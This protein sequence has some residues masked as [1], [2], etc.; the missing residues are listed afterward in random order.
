ML[1][2]LAG[3]LSAATEIFTYLPLSLAVPPG[4]LLSP[5]LGSLSPLLGSLSPGLSVSLSPELSPGLLLS[6]GLV[7]EAPPV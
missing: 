7:V 6:E 3:K 1:V 4:L 2:T 5:L